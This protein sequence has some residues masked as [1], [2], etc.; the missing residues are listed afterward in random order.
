MK[1]G[2]SVRRATIVLL[3][4]SMGL[5]A[6]VRALGAA[7][8]GPTKPLEQAAI[9]GDADQIKLHIAR[10]TPL[11][12]ADQ[13]GYTPLMRAIEG[14]HAEAAKVIIESG[15]AK[16][17]AKERD[18]K[19][20]LILAAVNAEREIAEVLIAKGADIK[21]KDN[22][23]MTALHAAIYASQTEVAALLIEKGADINTA[24][25][26]GMT[27]LML[28]R[29]RHQTEIAELLRQKGAKEPVSQDSLYGDSPYGGP[30]PQGPVV[31]AMPEREAIELDP[32]AIRAEIQTFE[33]LAAALKAVD[34]KS[35]A[36]QQAWIQRR[37][38]NRT[39]L[40]S[41]VERQ[42]SDEMAFLKTVVAEEGKPQLG[43]K[44][45]ATAVFSPAGA[46]TKTEKIVQAIDELSAARKK[47]LTEINNEL[48]EQRRSAMATGS[49]DG[50]MMG[51]GRAPTRGT[52]GPARGTGG[53]TA[54]GYAPAGPYGTPGTRTPPRPGAAPVEEPVLDPVTQ[55]Q[56]QAWLNAKPEDKKGLLEAVHAMNLADLDDLRLIAVEEQAKKTAVALQGL[57][58]AHEERVEKITAKWQEEDERMLKL[59]ER[60]G[61]GGM[62]G[63]GMQQPGMQPQQGTR[64]TRRGR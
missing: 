63:R 36:E 25:R 12:T 4:V 61:P 55:A 51:T 42:F 5:A 40:L 47:R 21:A 41:A 23:E 59:Q 50:G 9:E 48:R 2:G 20:A 6:S 22:N 1:K 39:V 62:P 11:N 34:D 33:G 15:K 53:A 7:Q 31:A 30:A 52:R 57:M 18:G 60:Y 43:L 64:G 29:Q 3:S 32:N 58:L 44:S 14:H 16:L 19:T 38:D 35:T 28:A 46:G 37:L 27:P 49:H 8:S 24:D 13:Y 45:L 10:G 17:D 56:V 54:P 26:T